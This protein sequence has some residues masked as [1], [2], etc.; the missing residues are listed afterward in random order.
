M[1]KDG[2]FHCVIRRITAC[3]CNITCNSNVACDTVTGENWL[4]R[5]AL[6]SFNVFKACL[7]REYIIMKRNWIV[8]SFRVAQV[9]MAC[10]HR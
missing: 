1:A 7:R 8:F 2:I 4:C 6:T 10:N 3:I 9:R 5:Y